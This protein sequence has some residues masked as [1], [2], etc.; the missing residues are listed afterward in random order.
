MKDAN[1]DHLEEVMIPIVS[2]VI[3]LIVGLIVFAWGPWQTPLIA[4]VPPIITG[5][6]IILYAV[7]PETM[8]DIILFPPD[9]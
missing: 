5:V 6:L 4:F 8:M 1:P 7:W 9:Q 3:A 2:F